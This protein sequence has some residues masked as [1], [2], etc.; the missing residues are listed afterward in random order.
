MTCFTGLAQVLVS[1]ARVPSRGVCIR[2]HPFCIADIMCSMTRR[3]GS[4]A[5]PFQVVYQAGMSPCRV[6]FLHTHDMM[7]FWCAGSRAAPAALVWRHSGAGARA[8]TALTERSQRAS[9]PHHP[10]RGRTAH[11]VRHED[12]PTTAPVAAASGAATCH[13]LGL[14]GQCITSGGGTPAHPPS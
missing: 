10:Q 14:C 5:L 9:H 13:S 8:P 12:P 11:C 1:N 4:Q 6:V 3:R 7:C 2:T